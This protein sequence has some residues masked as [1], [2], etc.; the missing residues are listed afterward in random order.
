MFVPGFRSIPVASPREHACCHC[1]LGPRYFRLGLIPA[2]LALF[3][4]LGDAEFVRKL[5][6]REILGRGRAFWSRADRLLATF[7]ATHEV[8]GVYWGN[9]C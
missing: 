8:T 2:L 1:A 7:G 6:Q 4:V 5:T 3:A 9:Y